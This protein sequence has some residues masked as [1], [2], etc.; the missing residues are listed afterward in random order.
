MASAQTVEDLRRLEIEILQFHQVCQMQAALEDH[1]TST[2]DQTTL[3]S[4]DIHIGQPLDIDEKGVWDFGTTFFQPWVPRE[5]I[6]ASAE[7]S[8]FKWMDRLITILRP[9]EW[10][11]GYCKAQWFHLCLGT[12]Y[13]MDPNLWDPWNIDPTTIYLETALRQPMRRIVF[14]NDENEEIFREYHPEAAYFPVDVTKPHV[15]SLVIDSHEAPGDKVLRSE[16]DYAIAMVL[17]RLKYRL[18]TNHHTKPAMIYTLER[19]QFARVTQVHY[20]GKTNKLVLRQSR[21]L[22]LRGPRPTEDAFTL[23]RWMTSRPVGDTEYVDEAEED[24]EDSTTPDSSNTAPKLLVGC[25]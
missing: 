1:D 21:H 6:K 25:A 22:D 17:F 3:E 18:H 19:D 2:I 13:E 20:D 15:A 24:E 7:D 10:K 5:V 11:Y 8:E 14:Y 16:V 23:L 9:V 4:L 12:L